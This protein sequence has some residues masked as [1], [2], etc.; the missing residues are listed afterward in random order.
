MAP[1]LFCSFWEAMAGVGSIAKIAVSS[2]NVA[3]ENYWTHW[4]VGLSVHSPAVVRYQ[5]VEDVPAATK[6]C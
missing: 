6:N 5:L 4:S 1:R 3:V 2:T